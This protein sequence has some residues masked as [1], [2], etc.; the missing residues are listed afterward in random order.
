M[1]PQTPISATIIVIV[2][3]QIQNLIETRSLILDGQYADRRASYS[4]YVHSFNFVQRATSQIILCFVY[5]F[6]YLLL[7]DICMLSAF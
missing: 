3:H 1:G 6:I 2:D 7:L 4:H 5:L